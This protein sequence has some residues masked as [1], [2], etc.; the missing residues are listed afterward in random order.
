[1]PPNMQEM[2]L[3]ML[4]SPAASDFEIL[5]SDGKRL[6]CSRKILQERWPWFRETLTAFQ[7]KT[8]V[9]FDSISSSPESDYQ[10]SEIALSPLCV[11]PRMLELPEVS[12]IA[13]AALQ[14]CQ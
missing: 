2:G 12:S 1:M 5:C 11:T 8:K 3:T 4:A 6:A 14:Y 7:S 10:S 13:F 9:A